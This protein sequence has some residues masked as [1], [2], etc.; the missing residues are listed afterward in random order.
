MVDTT[1]IVMP[2]A[3]TPIHRVAKGAMR[4]TEDASYGTSH[5]VTSQMLVLYHTDCVR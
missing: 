1:T 4:I 2:H 3:R 5:K